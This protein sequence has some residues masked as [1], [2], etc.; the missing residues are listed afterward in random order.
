MIDHWYVVASQTTVKIFK[1]SNGKNKLTLLQTF[2]NPLG[3]TRNR[4]LVKKEAGMGIRSRGHLGSVP[5]S[6]V[7]R[8]D[9]HDLIAIDFAKKIDV[10]LDQARLKNNYHS[11]TIIAEPHFLGK[12]RSS[13]KKETRK[14]VV[15]WVKKDLLK[16]PSNRLPDILLGPPIIL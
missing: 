7:S 12:I 15:D 6:K 8:S 3:R 1:E 13:M 5:Y 4:E 16:T 10:F 11:L 9:P 2:H 14:L